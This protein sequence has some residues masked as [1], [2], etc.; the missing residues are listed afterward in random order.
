MNKTWSDHLVQLLSNYPDGIISFNF[1]SW[2]L[3]IVQTNNCST[4]RTCYVKRMLWIWSY[5][6]HLLT[7][8]LTTAHPIEK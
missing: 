7:K 1:M 5:N 8:N 4:K 6:E 3:F 2:D